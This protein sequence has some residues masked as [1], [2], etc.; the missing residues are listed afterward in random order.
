[1]LFP[2]RNGLQAQIPAPLNATQVVANL[3]QLDGWR[4]TGDGAD[5]AIEKRFEFAD[6]GAS[7]AFANALAWI[8]RRLEKP[9]ALLAIDA[10]GSSVLLRWSS[11]P[12][13]GLS[14]RDFEAARLIDALVG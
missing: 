4:L 6:F 12:A 5:V 2:K 1:M 8:V 3:A 14:S 13:D 11:G 9:P 10:H 7:L